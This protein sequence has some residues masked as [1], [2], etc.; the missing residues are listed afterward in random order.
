[1]QPP[2]S[3]VQGSLFRVA[4]Q[5]KGGQ[6]STDFHD[7]LRS[8]TRGVHPKRDIKYLHRMVP[9]RF[10]LSFN[11]YSDLIVSGD[12]SVYLDVQY[13]PSPGAKVAATAFRI[14]CPRTDSRLQFD[15]PKL[16]HENQKPKPSPGYMA[17]GNVKLQLIDVSNVILYSIHFEINSGT[18]EVSSLSQIIRPTLVSSSSHAPFIPPSGAQGHSAS[19]VPFGNT[20]SSSAYLPPSSAASIP[21]LGASFNIHNQGSAAGVSPFLAVN[22]MHYSAGATSASSHSMSSNG[23]YPP[24]NFEFS[25]ASPALEYGFSDESGHESF[26]DQ[27][28]D[29]D[30]HLASGSGNVVGVKRPRLTNY[31][32]DA[33]RSSPNTAD[34]EHISALEKEYLE[35]FRPKSY[36]PLKN[37][38]LQHSLPDDANA[39]E[40]DR[41]EIWVHMALQHFRQTG[42]GSWSQLVD[43]ARI[44]ESFLQKLMDRRFSREN[45]LVTLHSKQARGFILCSHIIHCI[46]LRF[47]NRSANPFPKHLRELYDYFL[48]D[49]VFEAGNDKVYGFLERN[50]VQVLMKVEELVET[51]SKQ[52]A[53]KSSAV[54]QM[55]ERLRS[56]RVISA[57]SDK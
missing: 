30:P 50:L 23:P 49:D 2:D 37:L 47:Q 56:K 17:I 51:L 42:N 40:E 36:T 55:W 24:P 6:Q 35:S 54:E 11:T 29:N 28:H 57:S 39:M 9:Q 34:E 43:T 4:L 48:R 45:R 5:D 31:E 12:V 53:P 52:E 25:Q 18:L 20:S 14:P 7:F 41:V 38:F 32:Q 33:K 8:R 16:L 1:M 3:S 15:L 22:A 10:D 26:F 44:G 19:S 27:P 46:S 13:A 21:Q